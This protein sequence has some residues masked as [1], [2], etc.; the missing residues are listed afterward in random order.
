MTFAFLVHPRAR[1]AEDMARVWSPLGRVPER[2]YDRVLRRM[3]LPP[4][5]VA[6][7]HLGPGVGPVGQVLMV[8]SGSAHLLADR[9]EGRR[10]VFQAVDRAVR[11]GA[12]I[13][14][15]G[16]LTG[17]MT[18][19]G[20]ALRTRTDVGVTNGAAFTAAVLDAQVRELLD[21][22]VPVPSDRHVAVVG[23][24]GSVGATLTRLL[25]RSARLDRL[26]V[27]SRSPERL[28]TVRR[29]LP[30]RL[31]LT[32]ADDVSA[33]GSADLVVVLTGS[34]GA[35]LRPEHLKPDAVVLDA[36]QP[37]NTTPA[38]TRARPDVLVV[39]GGI[40]DV[41]T[42]RVRGGDLGLPDGRAYAC[43]AEAALL[44][45]AGHRGHFATGVP[46][47]E[48]VDQTR[49]LASRHAHL[50]F[51]PSPATSFGSPLRLPRTTLLRPL[52]HPRESVHQSAPVRTID[53]T[54]DA[55]L[56]W[57]GPVR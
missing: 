33:V 11:L 32:V 55:L 42:L 48:Q 7:V 56:P 17:S 54:G 53:L 21:D 20:A 13:V 50:G 3:P 37:R 12:D 22:A 27:V 51:W 15:L 52:P 40:V 45:L 46:T 6:E 49:E 9:H 14:G 26:T 25:A 30:S 10:R 44:H 16:V 29:S 34:P 23:A 1:L 4:L 35:L 39:D 38:L 19:G 18:A 47:L 24:T 28:D 41:P 5:R 31:P 57:A 8:P 36:T 43:L 2:A